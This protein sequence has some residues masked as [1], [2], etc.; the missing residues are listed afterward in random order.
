MFG[1]L[2]D[3]TKAA[4]SVVKLPVAVV[5]DAVTL[6]GSLTDQRKPYTA[7]AAEDLVKNLDNASKPKR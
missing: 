3:L 7:Q 2:E 4:V 1:L 5:A 6:G